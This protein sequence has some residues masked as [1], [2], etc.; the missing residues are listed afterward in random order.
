M[1]PLIPLICFVFT[2]ISLCA[3][4]FQFVVELSQG[5]LSFHNPLFSAPYCIILFE[6]L[7]GLNLFIFYLFDIDY[8]SIIDYWKD[9]NRREQMKEYISLF[10]HVAYF[11]KDNFFSSSVLLFF[12]KSKNQDCFFSDATV[13]SI[14][15]LFSLRWLF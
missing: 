5:S 15:S 11:S 12:S 10:Y 9:R 1:L 2:T 7:F 4:T 6:Y 8:R 14:W 13:H 3:I